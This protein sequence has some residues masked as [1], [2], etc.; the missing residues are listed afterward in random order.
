MRNHLSVTA[1]TLSLLGVPAL[2]PIA[3]NAQESPARQQSSAQTSTDDPFIW[4]E[5]VEG[6]R[7]MDWV[8]A[9]LTTLNP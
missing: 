7:S 2:A 3:V 6:K 4:L 8:N 5:D 9:K 1:I